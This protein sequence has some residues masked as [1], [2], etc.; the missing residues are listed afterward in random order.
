MGEIARQF[1]DGPC[2][3]D[4]R[5][6]DENSL[7]VSIPTGDGHWDCYKLYDETMM[8]SGYYSDPVGSLC[9]KE[10]G[11]NRIRHRGRPPTQ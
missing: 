10:D 4:M 3:G 1:I 6:V 8:W 2:H 5:V 9:I 7:G 11:L